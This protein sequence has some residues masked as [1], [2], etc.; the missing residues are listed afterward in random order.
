MCFKINWASLINGRKFTI[1]A[2]FYFVFE[3]NFQVQA[4]GGLYLMGQFNGG[5]FCV[6]SL[7]SLYLEGLIFGVLQYMYPMLYSCYPQYPTNSTTLRRG[8]EKVTFHSNCPQNN[9]KQGDDIYISQK[10]PLHAEGTESSSQK[11]HCITSR[12]I[13]V[14]NK[15]LYLILFN[16]GLAISSDLNAFF[17]GLFQFLCNLHKLGFGFLID[18]KK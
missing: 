14:K 17:L 2:L 13:T 11:V 10:N 5:F 9:F 8:W 18:I 16:H 12:N 15:Q 7:G 4:P 3:G 6:T 1:F